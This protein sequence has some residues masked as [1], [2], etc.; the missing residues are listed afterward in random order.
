MGPGRYRSVD[1]MKAGGMM[2][3]IFIIVLIAM[4]YLFYGI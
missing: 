4:L 1:F 2:S 3:I